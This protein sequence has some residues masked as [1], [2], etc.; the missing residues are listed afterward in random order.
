MYYKQFLLSMVCSI[1]V[2]INEPNFLEFSPSSHQTE[3]DGLLF[4]RGEFFVHHHQVN[5]RKYCATGI[6][7]TRTPSQFAVQQYDSLVSCGARAM[8]KEVG[9]DSYV[10][11]S[12]PKVSNN[13]ANVAGNLT[14]SRKPPRFSPQPHNISKRGGIHIVQGEFF[15]HR[16]SQ[17][18]LDKH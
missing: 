8:K 13:F 3:L 18:N 15:V 9:I 6:G 1:L 16:H 11:K 12:A 7:Q 2:H 10:I 17:V 4:N 14:K 5:L